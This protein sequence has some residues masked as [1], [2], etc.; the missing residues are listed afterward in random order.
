MPLYARV[1]TDDPTNKELDY[2]VPPPWESK[3]HVGSRVK[4]PL[5][6][7]NSFATVVEL[8]AE[9]TAPGIKAVTGLVSEEPVLDPRMLQLARWMADYYCCPLDAAVRCTLPQV[10]RSGAF[11]RERLLSVNL[12]AGQSFL[13]QLKVRAPRQAEV[14]EVASQFTGPIRWAELVEAAATS[15]RT[16]KHLVNQGWL[17]LQMLNAERDPSQ[18]E[19]YV[20]TAP[21][22][23]NPGQLSILTMLN[24][25]IDR[26]KTKPTLLHGITG[27]GKT[28]IYL[29]AIQHCLDLGRGALVLVPEISLTPQTV[30]RFK[31]RFARELIAVLHSHLSAGERHDEWHRLRRGAA[32]VAIGARSAVFAPVKDL[33]LIVVDEEHENSYKQEETPRYHARDL[34]VVRGQIEGCAVLLGSATPSLES[35]HNARTGKY[36]LARLTARVDDRQLPLIRVI[37]LRQEFAKSKHPSI[38]SRRLAQAIEDRLQ[39]REQSILFLNRRGFASSL[40]C[41]KCGYVCEC[42]NCSIP[43]TFHLAESRLKCHLCGYQAVAPKKCPGCGDPGIRYSGYGTE[44]VIELVEKLFPT[45]HA[46]RMDA[47]SMSRKDAYRTTLGAFRSGKI[48]ILIGTQMIAKGLDFPNVTLVGIINADIGLHIPDFRAGERTFQLLTQVAGRA[49]RGETPGEVFVQTATPFSPSVQFAR[50]HD[51]DGFW[52][53]EREFRERCDYPPFNHLVL[54]QIKSEHQRLAE[55]TAET[56]HRRFS[57]KIDSSVTLHPVVP[58]QIERVKGFYRFQ[59]LLRTRAIL[60]LSRTTREVMDSLSFPDEIQ[61]SVDVDPYHLL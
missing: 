51:F 35:Y 1:V 24:E 49:G 55:F 27:S 50:H 32:R 20:S 19:E 45:A 10:I 58:A 42:A 23:L 56:L 4:V 30:E 22:R 25:A 43:L 36:E 46:A 54:I 2:L 47:D 61:V 59:I 16:I 17:T 7:R 6:S 38:L 57:E 48:D 44:K 52:D 5:R 34:A 13:E 11:K 40:L 15:D 53:Q 33:A 60:R 39:K 18:G 8:V 29:Q 37:D 21:L 41:S 12:P 28:E 3:V 14:L 31:S 9:S 26:G